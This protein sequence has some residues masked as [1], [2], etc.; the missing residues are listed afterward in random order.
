MSTSSTFDLF[1]G[2]GRAETVLEHGSSAQVAQL[3]WMKAR[4]LPGRAV[5]DAETECRSLLC[6][7]NHAGTHVWVAGIDI[8]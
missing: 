4:R 8:G 2:I 7:M 5:L 1:D 6:L 3:G